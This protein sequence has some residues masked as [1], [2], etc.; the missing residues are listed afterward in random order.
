[1]N[2]IS[3]SW[4][5][6]FFQLG[7]LGRVICQKGELRPIKGEFRTRHINLWLFNS[8]DVNVDVVG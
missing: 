5:E 7:E 4:G 6:F 8:D 2:A 3:T 1:M